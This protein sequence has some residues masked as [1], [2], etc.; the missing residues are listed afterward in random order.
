MPHVMFLDNVM[1][2]KQRTIFIHYLALQSPNINII[3]NVWIVLKISI[4]R[5]VNEIINKSDLA[6]EVIEISAS[7][8]LHYINRI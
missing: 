7:L 6:R 4:K 3:E 8:P 2:G 1:H 5:R